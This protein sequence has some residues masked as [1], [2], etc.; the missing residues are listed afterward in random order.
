MKKISL[1]IFFIVC[2]CFIFLGSANASKKQCSYNASGT[3]GTGFERA[4]VE[5]PDANDYYK[6]FL[7]YHIYHLK[8]PDLTDN[9]INLGK[10]KEEK[11]V[12][13]TYKN[14]MQLMYFNSDGSKKHVD[15][16]NTKKNFSSD[17]CP[18]YI[19]IVANDVWGGQNY[20]VYIGDD[21]EKTFIESKVNENSK[22]N[23]LIVGTEYN[24]KAEDA[25]SSED[26]QE[27]TDYDTCEGMLGKIDPSTKKYNEGTT[28]YLLQEIFGYM[29]IAAIVSV[30]IFSVVD[31]AKALIQQDDQAFKTANTKTIKRIIYGV[32]FFLLPIIVDLILTIIDTS[33]CNVG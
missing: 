12:E 23:Y 18:K 15:F 7:Y 5:L 31:Y 16:P 19:F 25:D 14:N 32:V 8:Y 6:T 33:S 21:E 20:K 11:K 24:Y 2:S 30:F 3:N 29:K 17:T 9:N 4:T 1:Y 28:G 13:G 26:N 22:K 10:L 27:D